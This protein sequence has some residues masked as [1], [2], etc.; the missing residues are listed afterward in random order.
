MNKYLRHKNIKNSKTNVEV[1]G[2]D[3]DLRGRTTNQ[4]ARGRRRVEAKSRRPI[5]SCPSSR[6]ETPP[7][8]SGNR[9]AAGSG[10]GRPPGSPPPPEGGGQRKL[11]PLPNRRAGVHVENKPFPG[12]G[13]G[14]LG[15]PKNLLRAS[16]FSEYLPPRLCSIKLCKLVLFKYVKK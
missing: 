2:S 4:T 9:R 12:P 6:T 13:G 5:P 16:F 10:P 7:S 3:S 11:K 14:I 1:W 8:Q 15:S